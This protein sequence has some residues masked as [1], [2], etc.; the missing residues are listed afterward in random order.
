MSKFRNVGLVPLVIFLCVP[1]AQW[2]ADAQIDSALYRLDVA[3]LIVRT[4]DGAKAEFRAVTVKTPEDLRQG[5]MHIRFL[6]LDQ[7]MIFAYTE[8]RYLSMWMKNTY[9][10]L[11]M[12]F[13]A[14]DGTIKMVAH[15]TEPHSLDS[16]SS[17]V[18][19]RFVI[20]INAGLSKLV[21][22]TEG[23]TVEHEEI[24]QVQ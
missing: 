18:P 15:N 19:V 7:A 6:P 8:D 10:P 20:E 2:T 5:L 23:A 11:D 22:I 24:L 14:A 3:P 4:V 16:I 12:W 13:V 9:I 21:G 17:D 1:V